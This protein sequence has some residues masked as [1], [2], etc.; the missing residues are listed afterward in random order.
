MPKGDKYIG[1]T[2]YLIGLKVEQVTLS[3]SE[4]E[5]IISDALPPSAYKHRAFWSNS[6]SHSVAYGWLD[7][8]YKTV[9]VDFLNNKV[10]FQVL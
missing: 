9:N 4:I 3:F 5:N 2:N 1:L 8:G 6:R 7:A 10:D